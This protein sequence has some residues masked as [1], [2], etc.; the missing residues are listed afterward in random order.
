MWYSGRPPCHR[1]LGAP[2]RRQWRLRDRPRDAGLTLMPEIEPDRESAVTR[3]VASARSGATAGQQRLDKLRRE[4]PGPSP[5]GPRP[6]DLPARPRVGGHGC[7]RSRRLA[8][9]PVLRPARALH[10]R[11]ARHRLHL[12]GRRGR[13]RSGGGDRRTRLADRHRH[14]AAGELALGRHRVRL[15]R[16]RH[17]G[18]FAEQGDRVGELPRVASAGEAQGVGAA[19]RGHRRDLRRN[20]PAGHPRQPRSRRP[21][22]R[23]RRVLVPRRLRRRTDWDGCCCR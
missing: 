3:L 22:H 13:Q 7:Q 23:R 20:R 12:G 6:A 8:A 21:G 4:A 18:P 19:G 10:R 14:L 5:R 9:L 17:H 1:V 2:R 16:H 11:V 15:A